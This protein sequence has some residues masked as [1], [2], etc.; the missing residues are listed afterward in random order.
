MNTEDQLKHYET[1]AQYCL[2][3][4]EKRSESADKA[5]PLNRG[6]ILLLVLLIHQEL[7]AATPIADPKRFNAIR[8]KLGDLVFDAPEMSK[9]EAQ[10]FSPQ[11]GGGDFPPFNS[12]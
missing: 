8:E 6:D 9:E 11:K 2:S 1:A 3:R 12:N 7:Q 10:R 4:R 5:Y